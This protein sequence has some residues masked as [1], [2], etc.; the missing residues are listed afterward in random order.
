M[1][2]TCSSAETSASNSKIRQGKYQGMVALKISF[3]RLFSE[4]SLFPFTKPARTVGEVAWRQ[5]SEHGCCYTFR[6]KWAAYFQLL[7]G[8]KSIVPQG[9]ANGGMSALYMAV[10][11]GCVWMSVNLAE[12]IFLEEFTQPGGQKR[13]TLI[14]SYFNVGAL[15]HYTNA[16]TR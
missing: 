13:R 2:F 11:L 5:P 3:P 6:R 16:L 7:Q 14:T 8:P 12:V 9:K 10:F 15:H 1:V 4:L